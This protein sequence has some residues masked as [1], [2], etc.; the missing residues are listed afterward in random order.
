MSHLKKFSTQ[1]IVTI[2]VG[3][4]LNYI[5]SNIALLLRLPIYLDT[6]GTMLTATLFGPIAGIMT[7][8]LS[9]LLSGMTTDLFSLYYGPIQLIVGWMTGWLMYNRI[10]NEGKWV[11]LKALG[12][13]IAG[14][15]AASGITIYLFGGITSAG[16]SI[17]VQ[18][19]HGTG[20][21]LTASVVIVQF[22][23][24]YVDRLITLSIVVTFVHALLKRKKFA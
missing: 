3:V 13:S 16:S 23:T 20:L 9:A 12:I 5:G 21:N 4:A 1:L 22:L 18:L 10:Q 11:P 19:L 17:F 24:D 7:G 2:G 8:A 14:S 15:I 6:M